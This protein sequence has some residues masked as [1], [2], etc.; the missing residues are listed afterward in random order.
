MRDKKDRIAFDGTN[1]S[2]W[3]RANMNYLKGKLLWA[4]VK[5][6]PL[7]LQGLENSDGTVVKETKFSHFFR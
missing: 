3:E 2:E 4:V 5:N 1:Y 7:S 6:G